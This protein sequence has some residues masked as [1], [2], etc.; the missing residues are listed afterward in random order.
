MSREVVEW[1]ESPEGERW[2]RDIHHRPVRH[3]WHGGFFADVKEEDPA[4]DAPDP[5]DHA[6]FCPRAWSVALP[7]GRWA[8]RCRVNHHL[9][10]QVPWD[11]AITF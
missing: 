7:D 1:L 10:W 2:S 3:Y 5:H 4:G 9:V 8:V 6:S 11:P